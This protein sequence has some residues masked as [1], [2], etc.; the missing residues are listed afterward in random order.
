MVTGNCQRVQGGKEA[1]E[2]E[3]KLQ[4][5]T[6]TATKERKGT[7]SRFFGMLHGITATHNRKK[8]EGEA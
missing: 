1:G 6:V 5:V 2:K 8:R 4:E 3:A 7:S